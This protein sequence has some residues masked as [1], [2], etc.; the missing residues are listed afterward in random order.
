MF[1]IKTLHTNLTE[2]TKAETTTER[3]Y[4][5]ILTSC[6]IGVVLVWEEIVKNTDGRSSS[7]D[8]SVQAEVD[9][10]KKKLEELEPF[11]IDHTCAQ[12]LQDIHT[13]T[14]QNFKTRTTKFVQDVLLQFRN[15]EKSG[16]ADANL[17][18]KVHQNIMLYNNGGIVGVFLYAAPKIFFR[19]M[20]ADSDL[21]PTFHIQIHHRTLPYSVQTRCAKCTRPILKRGL[22]CEYRVVFI[23]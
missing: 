16:G 7:E 9:G 14:L 4:F 5:A 23:P 20:D 18:V 15:V 6:Y 10:I 13:R 11:I 3:N 19:A 2:I 1:C 17:I 12:F 22:T 8:Q 21:N